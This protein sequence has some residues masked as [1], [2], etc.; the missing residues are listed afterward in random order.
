M[1][2]NG[3]VSLQSRPAPRFQVADFQFTKS[4]SFEYH[5]V[6]RYRLVFGSKMK[7]TVSD[8]ERRTSRG[9][10]LVD[11]DNDGETHCFLVLVSLVGIL[12]A[13]RTEVVGE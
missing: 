12:A 7:M 2:F 8:G 4:K 5:I 1:S 13:S 6:G 3:V 9:I 11:G 10:E